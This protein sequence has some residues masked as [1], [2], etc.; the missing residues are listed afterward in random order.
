[1]GERL[2]EMATLMPVKPKGNRT[3]LCFV[4]IVN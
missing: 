2:C 3:G 4:S 1:M